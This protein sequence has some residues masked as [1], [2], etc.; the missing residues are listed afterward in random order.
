MLSALSLVGSEF[1]H[2]V[3]CVQVQRKS[4]QLYCG[5]RRIRS[6]S[7]LIE[8]LAPLRFINLTPRSPG[9]SSLHAA[10]SWTATRSSTLCDVK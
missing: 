6:L 1:V 3:L 10:R 4:P 5:T 9:A 8:P 2:I 7:L